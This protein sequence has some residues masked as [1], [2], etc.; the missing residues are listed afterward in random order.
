MGAAAL[1]GC[2]DS[3]DDGSEASDPLAD[4][5]TLRVGVLAPLPSNN[6]IGAS[7]ANGAKLAADQIN[8]ND[9]LDGTE[10]EVI[11]KD[12]EE[13]PQTGRTRYGELIRD[14]NVDVTVGVFTSEVL[15]AIMDDIA[16]SKVPH[17]TTG[18]ATPEASAK[19]NEEYDTYKYHFRAGPINAHHLGENLVDFLD[20]KI[21]EIGWDSVAVLVEDYAWTEPVSE[22]LNDQ[23]ADTG[24]EVA[25]TQ[26][27]PAGTEDFNP[28]YN[29]VENSGADAAYLAMAHTGTPAVIQWAQQQRPFEFAGI[30][31]PMQLPSYYD[32]VNGACA[33]GVTQNSATPQAAV[34]DTT[35]PF[36]DD[37]NEAYG[38]YP[39]YTGYISYDAVNQYADVVSESGDVG[40]NAV[41]SGLEDSSY[42]G[43][44]GT[45]EYYG[46]DD[47]FA[48]DVKYDEELVWPV[49]QQWQPDGEGS[50]TQEVIF[51]DDLATADYQTPPWI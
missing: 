28:I 19:V 50:G 3:T 6:P 17:I 13:A 24:V 51:P 35:V 1:A 34:T 37:Y 30:H 21:D 46:R 15:L 22:V 43:T 32:A 8:A 20:A 25:M 40:G 10:L 12:T 48:H 11:V 4:R 31:V 5:D 36:A 26:R 16:G 18:A 27:Y 2:S 49:F 29:E 45:L 47:E 23:L 14:E 7:I 33:Y 38:S 9:G 44:V 42:T 41:V 39:V